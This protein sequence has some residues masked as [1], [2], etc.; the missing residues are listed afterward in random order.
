MF[1][2]NCSTSA[3]NLDIWV[4]S[5]LPLYPHSQPSLSLCLPVTLGAACM[6]HCFSEWQ[7]YTRASHHCW[8]EI[9]FYL[10]RTNADT[11]NN[12]K[13]DFTSKGILSRLAKSWAASAPFSSV[14]LVLL[15]LKELLVLLPAPPPLPPIT[16][17]SCSSET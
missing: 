12:I 11:Q 4:L 3:T 2:S 1:L 13:Q 8:K 15:G 5:E 14:L 10:P 17:H 7:Q 16:Q 6:H 9:A